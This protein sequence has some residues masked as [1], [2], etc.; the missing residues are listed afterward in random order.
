MFFLVDHLI[1]SFINIGD[2]LRLSRVCKAYRFELFQNELLWKYIAA[3]MRIKFKSSYVTY[4]HIKDTQRCKECG[5]TCQGRLKKLC[6][7]CSVQKSNYFELIN[8]KDIFQIWKLSEW[9]PTHK[10]IFQLPVVR[11]T[12]PGKKHLYYKKEVLKL[13]TTPSIF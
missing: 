13:F 4:Q 6:V 3:Q 7:S 12:V 10:K 2:I 8:R 11:R 9:K 1:D 5:K